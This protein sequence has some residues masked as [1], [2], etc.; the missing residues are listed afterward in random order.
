LIESRENLIKGDGYF[1]LEVTV[2]KKWP[3]KFYNKAFL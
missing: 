1:R 2:E 3:R